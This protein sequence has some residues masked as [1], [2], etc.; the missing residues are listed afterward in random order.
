MLASVSCWVLVVSL[1]MVVFSEFDLSPLIIWKFFGLSH[2]KSKRIGFVIPQIRSAMLLDLTYSL[3][4]RVLTGAVGKKYSRWVISLVISG[5]IFAR[6]SDA[7]I[8]SLF[9]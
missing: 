3:I 4:I 7:V 2:W 1:F 6:I 9:L 5:F 8:S